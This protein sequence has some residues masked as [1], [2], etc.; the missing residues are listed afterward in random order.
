MHNLDVIM[1]DIRK[2]LDRAMETYEHMHSGHEAYAVI[3]EELDEYKEEVWK[4]PN[5]RNQQQMYNELIQ[6]A[7]MCVRAIHDTVETKT[8]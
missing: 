6:T 5:K 4:K 8:R 1:L 2:E 7:A 3:L